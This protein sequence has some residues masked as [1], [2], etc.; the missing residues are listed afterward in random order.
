MQNFKYLNDLI[1]K[2]FV[3][4]INDA[5]D[6]IDNLEGFEPAEYNKDFFFKNLDV[7]LLKSVIDNG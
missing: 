6:L 3:F 4:K 7:K 5:D 1:I 2:N